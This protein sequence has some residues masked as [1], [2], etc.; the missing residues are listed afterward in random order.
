MCQSLTDKA[1]NPRSSEETREF[2]TVNQTYKSKSCSLLVEPVK[3]IEDIFS[4][5]MPIRIVFL[6][7]D[8]VLNT[9]ES[10][11]GL[12]NGLLDNL[13]KFLKRATSSIEQQGEEVGI[14]FSSTWRYDDAWRAVKGALREERNVQARFLGGTPDLSSSTQTYPACDSHLNRTMEILG[15]LFL[16]ST[17]AEEAVSSSEFP[18]DPN[19]LAFGSDRK[20]SEDVF[21]LTEGRVEV[22][23]FLCIDDMLL[24]QKSC[25]ATS[26]GIGERHVV[27]KVATGFTDERAEEALRIFSGPPNFTPEYAQRVFSACTNK[28]CLH[29]ENAGTPHETI[30]DDGTSRCCVVS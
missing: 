18:W 28:K 6:D 11:G 9:A 20:V 3:K 5:R 15:W 7:V 4:L 10:N 27:T 24:D 21:R 16:N 23:H 17:H 25:F 19:G 2:E 14:V 22:S 26:A 30:V 1:E 29:R 8:G 13:A 12:E